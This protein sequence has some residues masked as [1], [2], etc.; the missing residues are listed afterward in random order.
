VLTSLR[1]FAFIVVLSVCSPIGGLADPNLSTGGQLSS[2]YQQ[3]SGGGG[4]TISYASQFGVNIYPLTAVSNIPS[5]VTFHSLGSALPSG[6]ITIPVP[7]STGV[8][9]P[10]YA[11]TSNSNPP[12]PDPSSSFFSASL[13]LSS[14]VLSEVNRP[15]S[16]ELNGGDF[17]GYQAGFVPDASLL[18]DTPLF[19]AASFNGLSAATVGH[20]ITLTLA[21][22]PV[23]G[24]GFYAL[25]EIT[26][27]SFNFLTYG[28]L[29]AGE[30]QLIL[31]DSW[32]KGGAQYSVYLNTWLEQP[33]ESYQSYLASNTVTFSISP[34]VPDG[35]T[36]SL[37]LFVAAALSL[38]LVRRKIAP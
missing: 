32:F 6:E 7:M 26:G 13:Y 10:G 16:L 5:S 38:A 19:T 15:I 21:T 30:T 2:I 34:T 1:P 3:T 14:P 22:P 23:N 18:P 4:G 24:I 37:P 9:G 12:I 35:S 27:G 25:A 28:S 20:D 8:F 11:A 17:S 33:G 36:D 29:N 31:S